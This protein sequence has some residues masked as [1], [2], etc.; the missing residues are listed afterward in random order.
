MLAVMRDFQ[1][2]EMTATSYSFSF[3]CQRK[4]QTQF[5]P[6]LTQ[7]Y[8]AHEVSGNE[9]E[10]HMPFYSSLQG[11]I[12][13]FYGSFCVG[14]QETNCCI[15]KNGI[16][17]Q[18]VLCAQ[19]PRS[20]P[21]RRGYPSPWCGGCVFTFPGIPFGIESG[22]DFTYMYISF[23][24]TRGNQTMERC[25]ISSTDFLFHHCEEVGEI[26]EKGF[27]M[28]SQMSDITSE[29]VLF[30]TFSYLGSRLPALKQTARKTDT[31]ALI[32]KYID[33]HVSD[34]DFSL[35]AI[36]KEISYNK[37]YLSSC[38]KK[39]MG[40]G[41][42]DYLNTVR[43]QHACHAIEQGFTCVGDIAFMCGFSDPQYFSKV[44]KRKTGVSPSAY[45][46]NMNQ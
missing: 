22:E 41:I 16:A 37:K 45:I 29:S 6:N 35:E 9:R 32:K 2:E 14:N 31:V 18:N 19:R 13:P 25:K 24:G 12:H 42:I 11:A 46:K 40:I 17:L 7:A 20:A 34:T 23:L 5:V 1:L 28:A 38:F 4:P 39:N 15:F 33:D 30:Y 10:K 44:F 8:T 27:A 36:C 26:W 43:I 21:Y 3:L